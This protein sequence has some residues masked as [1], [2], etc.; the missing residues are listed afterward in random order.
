V[1]ALQRAGRQTRRKKQAGT[2]QLL[3]GQPLSL[4]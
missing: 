4:T 2:W 3:G 1:A